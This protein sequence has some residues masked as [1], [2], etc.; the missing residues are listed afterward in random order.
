MSISVIEMG[1][2]AKTA[3]RELGQLGSN[4]KNKGLAAI[5]EALE[6]NIDAIVA[7]NEIDLKTAR[8][9]GTSPAMLDR[10]T[11]DKKRILDIAG[12][13]R[14]LIGLDD[15]VGRIIEGKTMGNGLIIQ[16]TTVPLGVVGII[17]EARPN[18]TV[19]AATLCLKSGNSCIL[20]GGKEAINSNKKLMEIMRTAIMQAGITEDAMNLVQDTSRES[21]NQMMK[22]NKYLD[23]LIPRGGAGLI[24]S[25]VENATVPVIQTG[26]GNCHVYVDQYADIDMAVNILDNAKTQ[27]PSVCNAAENVLVHKDVAAQFLPL[28]KA[29]LDLHNVEWRGCEKTKSILGDDIK[30]AT[31]KDYATEFIDYIISAKVVDSIDEAIAHINKYGTMHSECI[32]TK[33]YANVQKFLHQVDAAAVYA[34]AS[35]RFTDG[36]EFGLGA[37]MGISTQKLHARG[38]MGLQELTT[39]KFMVYGSGQIR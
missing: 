15:P 30:L 21:S 11:L 34:N 22:M 9:N 12:A 23:V 39:V 31:E 20:R 17:Y 4:Q 8:D 28:A 5:A 24:N 2:A 14:Q 38:P 25:V 6:N 29:R 19:D 16:K 18:V 27:R 3:A 32:V 37:E 13:V 10:L 35:T 33:D 1:K 26:T 36:G 7:A